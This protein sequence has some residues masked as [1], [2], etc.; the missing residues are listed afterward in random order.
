MSAPGT[1]D[2]GATKEKDLEPMVALCDDERQD[3]DVEEN[4]HTVGR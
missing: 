1:A 2:N 4:E 3:C